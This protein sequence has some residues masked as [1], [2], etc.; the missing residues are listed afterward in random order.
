MAEIGDMAQLVL[1]QPP[2]SNTS[3]EQVPHLGMRLLELVQQLHG[4]RFFTHAIDEQIRITTRFIAAKNFHRGISRM[5]L[6]AV[7]AR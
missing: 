6:T 7:S 5:Q 1:R 4:E 3:Q 2:S